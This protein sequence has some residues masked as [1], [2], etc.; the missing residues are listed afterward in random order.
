M[1]SVVQMLGLEQSVTLELQLVRFATKGGI[2]TR[3]LEISN[4]NLW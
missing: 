3:D 4:L 1:L 2:V